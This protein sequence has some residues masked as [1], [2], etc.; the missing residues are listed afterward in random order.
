MD[1]KFL[2]IVSIDLSDVVFHVNKN[3]DEEQKF[4]DYE[5]QISPRFLQKEGDQYDGLIMLKVQMFDEDYEE[6][7]NPFYLELEV[8]GHFNSKK[9]G[10]PF[11]K[12]VVQALNATIPYVRSFISTITALSDCETVTMPIVSIERILSDLKNEM[13][14]KDINKN[15]DG[16]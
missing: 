10:E 7:N 15:Q 16:N 4:K 12:Y 11:P 14:N 6:K 2:D 8:L 13:D 9:T 3:Y 5:L 1:Q